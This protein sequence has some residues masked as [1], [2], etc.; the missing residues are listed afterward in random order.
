MTGLVLLAPIVAI[1]PAAR[2]DDPPALL[3]KAATEF[4]G[5][6][7]PLLAK[8]CLKC[9]STKAME[10]ELDLERFGSLGDVR[11]ATAVWLKVGEMLDNGEMPPKEA[12]RMPAADR[13][14]LRDWLTRY[15]RAEALAGA[16]DPGPVVLRRLS[17]AQYTYTLRDLTGVPL[18]PAREFPVDGAAGE[19]FT[20][21]GNALVMSPA[22]LA[23]Y[24]D[25]AK[26]VA[27]HAVPLPDGLRFSAGP[28][29]R[30]W[31]DE[32]VG[33]I[34]S[35]YAEFT[36]SGGST[37]VNLQGIVFGTNAGGR[38]PLE[39]YL[40][41]TL[42]ERVALANGTKTVEAVAKQR[43]LSPKY[44]GI[45]WSAL[46]ANEP[47]P[48]LDGVR[49]R[50]KAASEADAAAIA[51]EIGLW[52]SALWKF[53]SVGQLG[54]IGGPKSWMEPVSPLQTGQEFRLPLAP[55][56]DGKDVTLF[57]SAEAASEGPGRG[58]VVWENPRLVSPGM[59][60][61]PLRDVPEVSRGL[62]A[63]RET[64]FAA[65]EK[66]LAAAVEA[67]E[68]REGFN[69][70]DLAR[71]HD[72]PPDVLASW[73][74]SLGLGSGP[75]AITSHLREKNR[76][77]SGFDFV[78]G[79]GPGAT[80]NV[81]ANSSDTH[82]RIPGNL[83]PHSVAMHPSPTLRVVA[84]WLSPVSATLKI[85]GSVQH[86]HPECGNGV[87]W[88]LEV[89]RGSTRQRLAAGVSQG[90]KVIPLGPFEGVAVRPG[91]LVSLAIGPR[92]GN[93]SCDL[94]AVDLNL[95]ADGQAWDLAGDVSPDILAGNPHADRLGHPGVWHFFTEP[96][97]GGDPGTTFPAGS[98]LA[99]WQSA[100][101]PEAKAA[102]GR[103][104]QALLSAGHPPKDGPDAALYRQLAS[105]RSPLFRSVRSEIGK[106][107]AGAPA[108]GIGP[109]T[110][111][112]K[113]GGEAI[114]P[115]SLGVEAPSLVEVTI[116]AGLVEGCEFV[117]SARVVASGAR[118]PRSS[119]SRRRSPGRAPGPTRPVP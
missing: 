47:S 13:Q 20:N 33:R 44:L 56:A 97:R 111:G 5:E 38:L 103:E 52:Q 60:D 88:A 28:T 45:L 113:P 62:L 68:A 89:R 77:G 49:S 119:R 80:P 42:A 117:T 112:K 100:T 40:A 22:L 7:R 118:R 12:K 21:T 86:A 1:V 91:D 41:A 39:H 30:D 3:A 67:G 109:A 8:Y 53:N 23:K 84:G 35:A 99:K 34:R 61:L 4:A 55:P 78:N 15:L 94:T 110:F 9:H 79:W 65:A 66:S 85:S 27:D 2:A 50:W 70:E 14:A 107:A 96:D 114:E 31:T 6:A 57:L 90:S 92:D 24:F 106:V 25:A 32:T 10:G 37:Q 108:P 72:V 18:D 19:G 29:R 71:K 11:K 102:L 116:P 69:P 115:T 104:V 63:R 82:V 26:G 83:R 43:K 98:V 76:K 17:N 75:V 64:V 16:G 81:T 101:T 93:Y 36:D 48:L 46:N 87:T 54:K 51:R 73:L 58:A 59:V 105:L 95:S 74:D